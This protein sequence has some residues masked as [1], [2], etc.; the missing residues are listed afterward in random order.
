MLPGLEN[1]NTTWTHTHT[2]KF[3]KLEQTPL[4]GPPAPLV[5]NKLSRVCR[6]TY[7]LPNTL[8]LTHTN[9]KEKKFNFLLDLTKARR[10]MK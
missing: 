4:P 8:S 3:I 2:H 5:S 6:C 9:K 1:I 7:V 10:E